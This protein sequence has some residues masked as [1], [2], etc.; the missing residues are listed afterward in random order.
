M[1]IYHH[2]TLSQWRANMI[3][4]LL[5]GS[6]NVMKLCIQCHLILIVHTLPTCMALPA[7]LYSHTAGHMLF[8]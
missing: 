8:Q 5:G 2:T 1:H 4:E 7:E 6:R 3:R